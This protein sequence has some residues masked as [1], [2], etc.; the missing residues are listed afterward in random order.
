MFWNRGLFDKVE[1]VTRDNLSTGM[2][3]VRTK[4]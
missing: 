2:T 1:S 3:E 4:R